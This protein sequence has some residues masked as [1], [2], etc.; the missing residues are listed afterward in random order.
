MW[1][2]WLFFNQVF[3][4]KFFF[5]FF[6]SFVLLPC[7]GIEHVCT[8]FIMKCSQLQSSN[9]RFWFGLVFC[10]FRAAP[11][12]YRGSQ[13]RGQ[14]RATA[15]GL[16]HSHSNARSESHLRPTLQL[17]ATPDPLTHRVRPGMEP[18]TSWFLVGFVSTAPLWE[19]P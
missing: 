10:L 18:A 11:A 8:I 7:Q 14:I 15:A 2:W 5:F 12:A 19:L 16:Y 13:A 17:T 1:G 4:P 3:L 9:T 6:L